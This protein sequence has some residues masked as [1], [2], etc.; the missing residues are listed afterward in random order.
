[1]GGGIPPLAGRLLRTFVC[2]AIPDEH[3]KLLS[4]WLNSRR[5]ESHEIRWVDPVTMHVTLKFCGERP[6][7]TVDALLENLSRIKPVGGLDIR[8][9][10]AGGFPD[11]RCPRVVWTGIAGDLGTLRALQKNVESAA[12]RSGIAKETRPYSPHLTLG[13]R[14]ST[15]PLPETALRGISENAIKTE[16]WHAEEFI[17][18]KSDL[19]ALGPKYT[20]LGLFKI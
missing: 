13:R 18:M 5:R 3:R 20:P 6:A 9:E 12:L 8:L 16:P 4:R 14:N 2:I 15:L 17:L 7:E 1:M 10:G 11:L 19:S